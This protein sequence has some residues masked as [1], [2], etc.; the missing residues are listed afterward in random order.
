[1]N[2]SKPVKVEPKEMTTLSLGF[3]MLGRLARET[4]RVELHDRPSEKRELTAGDPAFHLIVPL[5]GPVVPDVQ[6]RAASAR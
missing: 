4:N 2:T 5:D 1:M 6:H 3:P